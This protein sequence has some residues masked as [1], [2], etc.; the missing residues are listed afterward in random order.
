MAKLAACYKEVVCIVYCSGLNRRL[1][2]N[3]MGVLTLLFVQ[4][5]GDIVMYCFISTYSQCMLTRPSVTWSEH[6]MSCK[7]E[8]FETIQVDDQ[9]SISGV[10]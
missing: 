9:N 5:F 4:R 1:R 10:D 8:A 7:A 2:I 3:R 6:G